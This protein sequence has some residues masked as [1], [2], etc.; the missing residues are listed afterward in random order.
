MGAE[1]HAADD[2][3]RPRNTL[4]PVHLQGRLGS[5]A[6]R[7]YKRFCIATMAAMPSVRALWS[8]GVPEP[9]VT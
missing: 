2:T 5:L 4:A 6:E 1:K 8:R 9:A 7:E 3:G